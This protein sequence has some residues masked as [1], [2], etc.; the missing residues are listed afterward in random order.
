MSDFANQ[1][2]KMEDENK[3][4]REELAKSKELAQQVST[5]K[6]LAEDAWAKNEELEKELTKVKGELGEAKQAAQL[7]ELEKASADK[8]L[9]HLRKAVEALL[10]EFSFCF[11][12]LFDVCSMC[13]QC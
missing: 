5:A 7:K 2:V 12:L 8:A 6:K 1:F 13:T 4:L 10:G 9:G 3:R 11:L